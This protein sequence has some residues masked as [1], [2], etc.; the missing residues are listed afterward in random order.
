[1]TGDMMMGGL[2]VL[3]VIISIIFAVEGNWPKCTYWIGASIITC[4]V[5]W[6]K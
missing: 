2:L 4:S 1:M 5:L 3:Y 6:M